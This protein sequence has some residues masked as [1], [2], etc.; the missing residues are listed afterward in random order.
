MK[1]QPN[2]VSNDAVAAMLAERWNLN[3]VSLR[4][5]PVGFGSHH[6]IAERPGGERWFATVDDLRLDRLGANV[7]EAFATL[8]N[9]LGMATALRD[10]ARLDFVVG[11]LPDVDGEPIFR[12]GE[13]YAIAVF[14]FLDVEATEF[15]EFRRASDRE[16]AL[17]LVARVH[18]ATREVDTGGLRRDTL[19]VPDRATLHVALNQMEQPWTAGPYAEPARSLLRDHSGTLRGKLGR[20]DQ[21][22]T[23]VMEDSSDWVVSHGEPH[24]GNILRTLAGKFIMVDWD[25]VGYAPRERDLWMLVNEAHPDWSAYADEAGVA[26]LSAD[27]MDAYRLWWDLSEIAC[28]VG[29]C[30]APHEHTED[31]EIAWTSLQAYLTN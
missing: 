22:A 5:L 9:A 19:V 4:Y 16:E 14:P 23:Q 30:R 25:T 27:S 8:R 15:G 10:N 11:S 28:Y 1:T 20:F 6:W 24:S 13:R 21:I 17:R 26:A 18:N 31:M 12:L 2:D 3:D 29:W 7:D